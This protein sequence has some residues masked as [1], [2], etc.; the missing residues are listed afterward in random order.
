MRSV[1]S[2]GLVSLCAALGLAARGA[3]ADEAPPNRLAKIVAPF[4]DRQTLAVV[5]LDLMAFDA[6]KTIDAA[7]ELFQMPE[8]QRVRMQADVAPISVISQTLQSGQTADMFLVVSMADVARSPYFVVMPVDQSTPAKAIAI[9]V[10]RDLEKQWGRPAAIEQI[11]EAVVV[12]GPAT[13]ER[14][15]KAHHTQVDPAL[16]ASLA[17]AGKS[18]LTMA[19]I[20]SQELRGLFEAIVPALPSQLGGGPT[21]AFTRGFVWASIAVDLPPEEAAARVVVQSA[22]AEAAAAFE[23][24]ARKLLA[25]LGQVEQ[26]REAIPDFDAQSKRLVPVAS[27]DRLE[28]ELTEKNGGLTALAA[29]AGPVLRMLSGDGAGR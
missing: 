29:I 27:G 7:A 9:E 3:A 28:L 10:R 21:K 14:L 11:G 1:L 13:L 19:I 24:E 16:A 6:V 25:G 26:V 4:V 8:Q 15:K 5:H 2:L 17:A 18:S 23:R 22:D 12:G 20:P